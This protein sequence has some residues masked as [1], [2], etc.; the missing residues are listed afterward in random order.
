MNKILSSSRFVV[1]NSKDV[2]I[3]EEA[4]KKF[5]ATDPE[6]KS[7]GWLE[8]APFSIDKL[9]EKEKVHFLFL[10]SAIGFSFWGNPKWGI[11][12]N[13]KKFDG[14]WGLVASIARSIEN[15]F[16]LLDYV[17]LIGITR[18]ELQKVLKGISEIPLFEERLR[19]LREVASVTVNIYNNDI[20]NLIRDSEF[21]VLKFQKELVRHFPSFDDKSVFMGEIVYYNK[22]AQLFISMLSQMFRGESLGNFC[23]ISELSACADYKIP[24]V[25]RELDILKY[26]EKI[27]DI[28][29]NERE[30]E[31]DSKCENEIRSNTI[32]A[33]ENIRREFSSLGKNYDTID[34]NDYIWLQGQNKQNKPYHKTKTIAY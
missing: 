23:N 26:S 7:N 22:R 29:D 10:L 8:N 5:C 24:Q 19:I 4:I 17:N 16:N 9:R 18:Q 13:N 15:G 2:K 34:I 30:V 12:Y 21:D 27:S 14:T 33:I 31:K 32:W 11:E 3:Q 28:I 6:I 1:E 20:R 25:L